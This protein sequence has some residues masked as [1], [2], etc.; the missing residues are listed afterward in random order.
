M[1]RIV[2]L[3]SFI[4]TALF[5]QMT[6]KPA[7]NDTLMVKKFFEKALETGETYSLLEYLSLRIGP[8]LSGSEGAAKAVDWTKQVMENYG[9]DNVFL[10]EMMVPHWERGEVEAAS[11]TDPE[12]GNEMKLSILAVGGSV[13]TPP[14][15]L[16]AEVV[17]VMSLDEVDTLGEAGVKGKI[18]FFNRPFDQKNITTGPGYGG[19]VDQRVR[20][21]SRA[22]KYGAVG[23]VIRS[24]TSSF[25]DL[26]HTGTLVYDTEAPRIPAAALGIQS[27]NKLTKA[28]QSKPDLKLSMTLSG[29]WFPDA[30]SHNVVGELKGSEFPEKY[31]VVGG[32]LDSWDVGHGAHDD[33]AG[34]MQSI[35]VIRLFKLLGIQP[36]HTIR[37]VMF[38]NEENGTRGGKKYAELAVEN[39]EDHLIAIESDA[40]GFTPRGFGVTANDATIEKM[41]S[42]LPLFHRATISYISKGGGGVDI[43]PLHN[44]TGTPMV[45]LSTDTQRLFD[46]HHSGKDVFESVNRRELEIGAAS[47]AAFIYLI[48]KHGLAE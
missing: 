26:P 12:S 44:A 28:L 21:A 36:R 17:P 16:M 41:R 39:K 29:Q 4:S 25:D 20:G 8:R 47:M 15:G 14:E 31:I 35:S 13:A 23:V 24:V 43:R 9:F 22:A 30:V 18:V 37:A 32:H 6:E 19:A 33:G 40:G 2:L 42:W 27:A 46:V 45:G 5:A 1:L 34:C 10:Q 7:V 3:I 11:F 38:M 48:D